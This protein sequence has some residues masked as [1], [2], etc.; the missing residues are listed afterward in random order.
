MSENKNLAFHCN[1]VS[2]WVALTLA[3]TGNSRCVVYSVK[4][5]SFKSSLWK[6]KLLSTVR[7]A[8]D[9]TYG[10]RIY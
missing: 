5:Y 4:K 1:V 9:T 2:G 8:W 6:Q 7:H 10:N 3:T